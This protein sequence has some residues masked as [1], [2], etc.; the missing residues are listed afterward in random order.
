MFPLGRLLGILAVKKTLDTA[1]FHE[2]LTGAMLTILLTV[3][4]ALMLGILIVGGLYGTYAGLMSY[5]LTHDAA[6]I[7]VS[8]LAVLLTVVLILLIRVQI[9]KM[10][11]MIKNLFRQQSPIASHITDVAQSFM[12]GLS[13]SAPVSKATPASKPTLHKKA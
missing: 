13:E 8:S 2:L 9:N 4:T 3:V 1:V 6:I 11:G 10:H 12:A 7:M 5:G